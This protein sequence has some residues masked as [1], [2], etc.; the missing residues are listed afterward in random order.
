[1][2]D[3]DSLQGRGQSQV[4]RVEWEPTPRYGNR[5][6]HVLARVED[7]ALGRTFFLSARWREEPFDGR[8]WHPPSWQDSYF[9][10]LPRTYGS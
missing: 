10:L 2:V 3:P 7:L 5:S 4:E 9:L 6:A 1:M 8:G